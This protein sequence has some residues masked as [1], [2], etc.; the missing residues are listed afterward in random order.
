MRNVNCA[1]TATIILHE[2]HLMLYTEA[3][4]LSHILLSH[5]RHYKRKRT[6]LL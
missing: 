4:I 5:M 2:H 3:D 1:N 6:Q